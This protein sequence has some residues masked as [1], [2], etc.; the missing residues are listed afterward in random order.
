MYIFVVFLVYLILLK[1]IFYNK[2]PKKT[3]IFLSMLPL[4]ILSA[5]R[6]LNVG[7]DTLNYY[8]AYWR[9]FYESS[10]LNSSIRFE[11]GYIALM[12]FVQYFHYDYIVL[13]ILVA[14]IIFVSVSLF[15]KA[16]SNNIIFSIYIFMTL[17]LFFQTMNISRQFIAISILVLSIK[18]VLN[19]NFVKFISM[20]FV[21]SLFHSTAFIFIVIYPLNTINFA[22]VNKF[23]LFS[24]IPLITIFFD[25]FLNIYIKYF[26]KYEG[27][28]S[29][30]YFQSDGNLAIYLN[31]IIYISIAIYAY[32]IN[33]KYK[34]LRTISGFESLAFKVSILIVVLGILGLKTTLVPR[35]IIYFSI[36][37]II[38]IPMLINRIDNKY[39]KVINTL[40]ICTLLLLYFITIAYLR[41]NWTGVIP[42]EFY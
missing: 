28:L 24:V 7:N 19:R 3:L 26:P 12:K 21:A 42:Y 22:K 41:P 27:Y 35:L 16:Y 32:V 17:N 20:V 8:K 6:S 18:Y 40:L 14:L 13:Q 30:D 5:F 31:L 38:Y 4:F 29:S 1:V 23:F 36:F 39:I 25:Y 2:N 9:S 33:K 11:T 10:I 37:Y 34:P 15:L